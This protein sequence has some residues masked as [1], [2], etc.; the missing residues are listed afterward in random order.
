MFVDEIIWSENILKP[1][2]FKAIEQHVLPAT[3]LLWSGFCPRRMC[4]F[5]GFFI[6]LGFSVWWPINRSIETELVKWFM[7]YLVYRFFSTKM[8]VAPYKFPG[9]FA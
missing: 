9:A 5:L 7:G 3:F 8:N 1:F 6:F 2:L 4:F